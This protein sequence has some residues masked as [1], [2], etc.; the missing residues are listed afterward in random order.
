[1]HLTLSFYLEF[2]TNC[3]F[4]DWLRNIINIIYTNLSSFAEEIYSSNRS[5]PKVDLSLYILDIFLK[6]HLPFSCWSEV[7]GRCKICMI[8]TLSHK[9]E[10]NA[11]KTECLYRDPISW[12]K[13]KLFISLSTYAMSNERAY[14]KQ[15][16]E[17]S[18][19]PFP[20]NIYECQAIC[21]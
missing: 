7:W 12:R 11:G 16:L 2:N 8:N 15:S 13:L 14:V 3:I 17:L 10:T 6:Y 4:P 1:M 9:F 5:H 19:F 21:S 20:E 18:T